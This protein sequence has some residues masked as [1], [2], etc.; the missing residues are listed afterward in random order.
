MNKKAITILGAIFLLIVG[1]LGF[2]IYQRRSGD[3][4]TTEPT[5]PPVDV[6]PPPIDPTPL[7]PPTI[8]PGPVPPPATNGLR[9][10]QL[11]DDRVVSPVLFYQGNGMAY[12]NAQGQLFQA[13]LEPSNGELKLTNK[14]ELGVPQKSGVTKILWPA[15]GNNYLAETA[16]GS[17]RT[18]SVYV[19]ERGVYVDVPR[20]ATAIQWMPDG[21]QLLYLWLEGDKTNLNLS[22]ADM[23]TWQTLTDMWENDDDLAVSPDGRSIL[24]WRTTSSE[25]VNKINM[26]T[27][28]GKLFRS[29]VKDGYNMG[30]VWSPDSQ[31]FAF[32]RKGTD[33]K[34]QLWVANLFT[35][36][37]QNMN[38]E[39]TVE[40][41][42]WAPDS[43][44]L[45]V[46]T[47]T[48]QITRVN[49]STATGHALQINGTVEPA[50]MFMSADGKNLFFK[51]NLD[52]GLYY[53]DVS[54]IS[55]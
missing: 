41:V 15:A 43:T 29:V 30:A 10:V 24:F 17:Q 37:A 50:N 2:L 48:G 23:S 51:N 22:P 45:Y 6:N 53:V 16:S 25:S 4:A 31:R 38:T 18:W 33:G 44:A 14:R 39:A 11:T 52:G 7:P 35:G 3:D 8:D 46:A 1:T 5:P 49:I 27:P 26:V 20:E 21:E 40:Q 47:G 34:W 54:G 13:D 55:S 12:F 28:D 19:S 42:T 36:E 32:S 9:P